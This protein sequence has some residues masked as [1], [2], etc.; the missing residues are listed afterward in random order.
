MIPIYVSFFTTDY[1]D[2]AKGL[3]DSL[4][5]LGLEHDVRLIASRGNW[6]QNCSMKCDV[7]YDALDEFARPVVWVDADARIVAKPTLFDTMDCDF[8]AHWFRDTELLSGTAFFNHTHNAFNLLS[9]WSRF[10]RSHPGEWDQRTLQAAV[11][12]TPGLKIERLPC[13]YTWICEP[14]ATRDISEAHYGK[15]EPVIVHRQASRRKK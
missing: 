7:I 2:E 12:A 11:D 13:E 14:G 15:R 10:S 5:A 9:N 1:A 8:A 6:V 3:I 4:D